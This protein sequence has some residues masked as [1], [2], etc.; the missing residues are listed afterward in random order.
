MYNTYLIEDIDDESE[1]NESS[2][3][4]EEPHP[5]GDGRLRHLAGEHLRRHLVCLKY[6]RELLKS[7]V[8]DWLPVVSLPTLASQALYMY[9]ATS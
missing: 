8:R 5:P 4:G 2:E 3:G 9:I 7:D 1:Q 6:K